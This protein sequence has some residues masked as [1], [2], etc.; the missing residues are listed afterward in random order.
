MNKTVCTVSTELWEAPLLLVYLL[1]MILAGLAY[2]RSL[3]CILTFTLMSILEL[4][5]NMAVT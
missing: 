2:R 1:S 5:N 3:N 4:Y